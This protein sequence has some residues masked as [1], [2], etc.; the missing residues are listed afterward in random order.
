MSTPVACTR[1]LPWLAY[2][3]TAGNNNSDLMSLK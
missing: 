1:W 3:T 2:R